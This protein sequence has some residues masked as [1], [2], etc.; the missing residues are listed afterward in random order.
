V[1]SRLAQAVFL[2]VLCAISAAVLAALEA[3]LSDRI[4]KNMGAKLRAGMLSALGVEWPEGKLEETYLASVTLRTTASGVAVFE[5]KDGAATAYLAKGQLYFGKAEVIVA[6]E[7]DLVTCRALRVISQEE[8]PGLG[9]RMAEPE[10]TSR[11]PGKK[12]EPEIRIRKNASGENEVDAITGASGTSG[13]L[14]KL[15]NSS[16]RRFREGKS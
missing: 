5:R 14:E 7:K 2:V 6:L 15:L 10:F 9:G 4:G 13:A 1:R 12:F 8:T 16:Y 3:S 11:L